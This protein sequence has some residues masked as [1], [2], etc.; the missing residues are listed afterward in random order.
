MLRGV[1]DLTTPIS[2]GVLAFVGFR[3]A[4]GARISASGAG[5]RTVRLVVGRIGWRHVWPIPLVLTV[6]LAAA[7]ALS[8]LPVLGWGWWT[9]LGGEGNPVFGSSDATA[10]TV[11]EWLIPLVFM[12]MLVPALPLFALAEE[13]I[14]RAGAE[15][16][17][18]WKR[19]WKTLTF[20]MMHAL[21][22]IP[23]GAALALSLGGAYFMRC[24]L[25]R[26]AVTG[27]PVDATYESAAAH[28]A[29]NG[30]ILTVVLLAL[31]LT[32]VGL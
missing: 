12:A 26:I 25:R 14:F 15:Q 7:I 16:W 9:M 29:Y 8:A 20:G 31:A 18:W 10:G 19:T 4:S 5:R 17:S 28:T 22:G 3:L 6:V 24:Y 11:W 2:V 27:S 30:A 13:R 32:A 23:L 21:V 1:A